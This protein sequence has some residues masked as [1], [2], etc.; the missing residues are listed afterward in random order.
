MESVGFDIDVTTD[1][2]NAIHS[3]QTR[4]YESELSRDVGKGSSSMVA[5]LQRLLSHLLIHQAH[6]FP[7]ASL[8]QLSKFFAHDCCLSRKRKKI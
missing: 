4:E 5:F 8:T 2:E 6:T 3:R 7:F 1:G